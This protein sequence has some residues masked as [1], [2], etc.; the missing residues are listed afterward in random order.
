MDA[1]QLISSY[2]T[3]E[4]TKNANFLKNSWAN[5]A[6]ETNHTSE[7]EPSDFDLNDLQQVVSKSK[8]KKKK[9]KAKFKEVL[10]TRIKVGSNK[11]SL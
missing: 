8:G 3:I 5:M 11:P 2:D 4:V 6:N 1:I 7:E 10:S 9:K